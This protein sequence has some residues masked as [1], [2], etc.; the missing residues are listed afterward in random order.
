VAEPAKH[1]VVA[2]R[3]E[4]P[5]VLTGPPSALSGSVELHNRGEATVVLRD[6]GLSDP[7]G[8]VMFRRLRSALPPIVLRPHQ[9]RRVPLT[10]AVASH[11]PPGE[12]RAE[13]KIAGRSRP[14]VL[15][16]VEAFELNVLPQTLVVLNLPGRTQHKRVIATNRG[17]VAFAFGDIGEVDLEDD[18][19]ADRG[20]RIAL[21]PWWEIVGKNV[22][23]PVLALIK[24]DHEGSY[25]P[26]GLSVRRLGGKLNLAPGE[27]VPIDL[28]ITVRAELPQNSRYRGRA[29]LLTS[30]L[31][32]VVVSA[33]D[34][35]EME[36]RTVVKKA[37]SAPA[38]KHA[39]K[40][41]GGR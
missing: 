21:Q 6:A 2:L 7:S 4:E 34:S 15:C 5:L 27:T 18:V 19:T 40:E 29:P 36:P 22:S 33:G 23:G 37:T 17:N 32:F 39:K 28:E 14:V 25:R 35:A 30:D 3:E 31:E 12:Y 24:I 26:A 13:L 20:A 8:V 1:D 9:E 38:G 16:V 11:T 41:R 10:V